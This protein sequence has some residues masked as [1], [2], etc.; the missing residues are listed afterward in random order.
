MFTG[1]VEEVGSVRAIEASERVARLDVEARR[2][3]R[4][5]GPS[6]AASR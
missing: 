3:D 6:A 5:C 2:H 1:I 4:G